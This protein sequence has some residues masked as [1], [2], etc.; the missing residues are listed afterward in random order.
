MWKYDVNSIGF[1][2]SIS[3]ERY[4]V[5]PSTVITGPSLADPHKPDI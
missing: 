1:E 3:I 2:I 4:F 5:F